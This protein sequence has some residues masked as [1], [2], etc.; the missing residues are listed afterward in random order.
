MDDIKRVYYEAREAGHKNINMDLILGLP[1]ET[2]TEVSHTMSEIAL[3][4]PE[5]LTVHT[6]AVKRASALREKLGEYNLAKAMQMEKM[7]DISSKGAQDMGLSPYYMYRQKN[8]LGSFEN[9]GY[10]KKGFESVYNV[11]IMEE[12]QT[13]F[14]AGAGASTK[15]YDRKS[16]RIERIFNVK[17]VDEY[18]GRIDEMIDR[19]RKG[20][21][22]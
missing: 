6:L 11:V 3:L 20:I 18:I 14:A 5:S 16:G 10:S 8:M 13:I 21:V 7:L 22:F 15:L 9:V 12:T 1:G 17:N 2:E 4:A 19:K